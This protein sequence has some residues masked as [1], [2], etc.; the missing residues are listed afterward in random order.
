MG[1]WYVLIY[2]WASNTFEYVCGIG[3]VFLCVYVGSVEGRDG[4][5]DSI[6][7]AVEVA[8]RFFDEGNCR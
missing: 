6:D 2:Y 1:W 7:C 8:D 3:R 5:A 4:C